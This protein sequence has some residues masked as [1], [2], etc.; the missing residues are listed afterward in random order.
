MSARSEFPLW[1]GRGIRALSLAAFLS[2]TAAALAQT[3][4]YIG[5]T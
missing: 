1:R 3:R 2:F 5:Y 4:P